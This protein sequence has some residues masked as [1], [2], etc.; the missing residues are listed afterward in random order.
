MADKYIALSNGIDIEVEATVVGGTVAQAGDVL[1]LDSTGRI[2]SSVLPVGLGADT[3]V[4]TSAEVL[5]SA[6]PMVY[7]K[8]DGQVANASA[9]SGG[10]P[11]IGF[12]ISN[13]SFG[14][15][16]I[17]YFEGRITGLSG[18]TIG[19]RYYLSDTVPGGITATPV[20]GTGKLHQ[21]IGRAVSATTITFECDDHIVRA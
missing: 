15:Q 7:I 6:N 3:L 4:A 21:Y 10:N 17:V 9:T 19:A 20:T 13:Y 1:A 8:S 18:L 12:V 5:S 16:A 2:D 14:A 11:T